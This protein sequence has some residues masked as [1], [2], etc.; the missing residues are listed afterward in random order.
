MISFTEQQDAVEK[1]V[2]GVLGRKV[3]CQTDPNQPMVIRAY[4]MD[5]LFVVDRRELDPTINDENDL[6]ALV[7]SRVARNLGFVLEE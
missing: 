5:E 1:L 3:M 7:L 6:R 2:E 4:L